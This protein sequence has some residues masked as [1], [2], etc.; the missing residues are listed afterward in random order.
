MLR[1]LFEDQTMSNEVKSF[2][3]IVSTIIGLGVFTLP[4]TFAKSGYFFLIWLVFWFFAFLILHLMWGEILLQTE[5]KHNLPGLTSIY[6]DPRLKHIVWL[7]DFLGLMGV[8]LVYFIFLVK[9]WQLILPDLSP[10]WLKLA[11]ALFNIYF[12]IK[13]ISIFSKFEVIL[14]LAIGI[15]F[16]TISIFLLPHFKFDNIMSILDQGREPFLPYGIILF[17]LSGT[18][19]LPIVYDLIGKNRTSYLKVN[20]Y[21]LLF[22]TAIYFLYVFSVSGVL[23]ISASEES[24]QSLSSHLPKL[25]LIITIILVTLNITF[26][27]MAFYLKR[28]LIFD[29][30][31]SPKLANFIIALSTLSLIFW[32][33]DNLIY[34]IDFIS[35][36]FLAFNLLIACLIY[37]KLK[38]RLFFNFPKVAVTFLILVFLSGIIWHIFVRIK[39]LV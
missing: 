2:F 38:K 6:L 18:S 11:F 3:I 12:I 34:L 24:L 19:A 16:L 31:L 26:I 8:F 17:A 25:F 33:I 7:F 10:F 14:G 23:G 5:E 35:S 9:F 37:L 20:F 22:V 4:D 21:S 28:G 32:Q 15:I 13:D 27:D 30:Q 39:D 1:S 29:Y 36:F